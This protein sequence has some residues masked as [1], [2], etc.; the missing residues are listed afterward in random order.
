MANGPQQG[1]L[2]SKAA[3]RMLSR[4]AALECARH[5]HRVRV[6]TVLPGMVMTPI[7][8]KTEWWPD[9]VARKG[10]RQAAF[11]TLAEGN[12]LKRLATPEEVAQAIL[13]LASDEAAYVTG[14][15]LMVDGGGSV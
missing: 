12:P 6:N 13:F 15:E 10:S 14:S 5:G 11:A 1:R 7:W 8:E 3:V 2:T 4:V 9:L